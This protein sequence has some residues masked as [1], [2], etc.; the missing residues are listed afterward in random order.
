MCCGGGGVAILN[1][2][3]G[4]DL[5]T[6]VTLELRY[7]VLGASHMVYSGEESSVQRKRGHR[8][9]R[10]PDGCLRTSQEASVWPEP[11]S[12]RGDERL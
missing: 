4:K 9:Y 10:K 11:T 3:V 8:R 7:K 12:V 5:P 1:R 2:V 6:K